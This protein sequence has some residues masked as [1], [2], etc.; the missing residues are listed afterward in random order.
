[1]VLRKGMVWRLA[2]PAKV[3]A[4]SDRRHEAHSDI[5]PELVFVLSAA[6]KAGFPKRNAINAPEKAASRPEEN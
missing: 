2:K 3:P 4:K 6:A 1:M 5:L